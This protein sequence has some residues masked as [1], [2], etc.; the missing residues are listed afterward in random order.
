MSSY[1]VKVNMSSYIEKKKVLLFPHSNA[2]SFNYRQNAGRTSRQIWSL[3]RTPKERGVGLPGG[4]YQVLSENS[5]S[6]L[7]QAIVRSGK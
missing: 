3:F 2:L 5:F 1:S 7:E 4:S 6:E